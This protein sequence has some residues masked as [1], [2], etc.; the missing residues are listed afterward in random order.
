MPAREFSK[1]LASGDAEWLWR[2]YGFLKPSDLVLEDLALARGVVVTYGRLDC[3]EA[4]LVRKG[5]HGLIR[6]REGIPE[7]GRKR[8]AIAHELGHWELHKTKSQVFTCTEGD[9]VA[10]YRTS[11][12]EGE[13]NSFAAGLLMPS[14]L[15]AQQSDGS[16]LTVEVVSDLATY[17]GTSFTATAIRYVD[18]SQ[19]PCAVVMS[20][21]GRLRW[22]R[23]SKEFERRFWLDARSRLSTNTVAGSVFAGG[24]RP[25]GPEEIDIA[26]WS[27][28]VPDDREDSVFIEECLFVDRY[29]QI[30]SLL[31]M[32]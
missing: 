28:R 17:F 21:D 27:D 15:F 25:S 24:N 26:A 11:A 22:W 3:V 13:A 16:V 10:S 7:Y 31:R 9:M 8:F 19:D 6:I 30:I 5:S 20:S 2:L 32:P 14:I 23:G 12:E 29:D 1:V 18:T 4:R